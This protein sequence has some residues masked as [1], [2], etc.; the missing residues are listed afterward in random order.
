MVIS[1]AWQHRQRRR[2]QSYHSCNNRGPH[3]SKWYWDGA[4]RGTRPIAG[5]SLLPVQGLTSGT[6]GTAQQP[7]TTTV[8]AQK[9]SAVHIVQQAAYRQ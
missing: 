6:V 3:P 4:H 1:S 9:S 2:W 7:A 8:C 5:D